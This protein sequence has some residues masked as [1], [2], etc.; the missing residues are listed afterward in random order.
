MPNGWSSCTGSLYTLTR[1]SYF[2]YAF[3]SRRPGAFYSAQYR[4]SRQGAQLRR[5]HGG[6]NP[7]GCGPARLLSINF[8]FIC[9]RPEPV[10]VIHVHN[11]GVL[12]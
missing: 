5:R 2:N 9:L 4:R 11:N 10:C 3:E 1:V 8:P 12:H 7:H 6:F